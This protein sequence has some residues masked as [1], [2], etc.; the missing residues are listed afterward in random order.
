MYSAQ[1][2]SH[3][4]TPCWTGQGQQK[5]GQ[6]LLHNCGIVLQMVQ[7]RLLS[8]LSLSEWSRSEWW[9]SQWELGGWICC[10]QVPSAKVGSAGSPIILYQAWSDAVWL[11]R[12]HTHTCISST[13]SPH[14]CPVPASW[15][16]LQVEGSPLLPPP[17]AS[18]LSGW[19][20][21]AAE[22]KA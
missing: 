13:H 9:V 18:C 11:D 17:L 7:C 2:K 14:P 20:W 6:A 19:T 8:K 4:Q 1:A 15:S 16:S 21:E 3:M 5:T 22:G 10:W 12:Y